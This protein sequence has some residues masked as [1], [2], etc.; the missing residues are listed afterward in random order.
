MYLWEILVSA[1]GYISACVVAFY[2]AGPVG[3]V[4]MIVIIVTSAGAA[5]VVNNGYMRLK[6]LILETTNQYLIGLINHTASKKHEHPQ[7]YYS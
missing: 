2:I 5:T 1:I 3:A 6:K 4:K 7:N